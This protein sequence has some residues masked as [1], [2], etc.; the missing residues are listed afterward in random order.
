MAEA[1]LT[2]VLEARAVDQAGH[3]DVVTKARTSAPHLQAAG[4]SRQHLSHFQH[5]DAI[6]TK[7]GLAKEAQIHRRGA[8]ILTLL[9]DSSLTR[10]SRPSGRRCFQARGMW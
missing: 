3:V 10:P 4:R 9:R 7:L 2:R 1:H 5:V 8:A 6:F